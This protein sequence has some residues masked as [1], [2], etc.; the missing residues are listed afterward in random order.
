MKTLEFFILGLVF[1]ALVFTIIILS[2]YVPKI[3]ELKRMKE[4]QDERS[5]I[6]LSH[7]GG[8]CLY[9]P[10][11]W[12]DKYFNYHI[13]SW[14]AGKNWYAV[15]YDNDWGI[16][17]LGDAKEMYPGLLEHIKAIDALTSG[18]VGVDELRSAGFTVEIN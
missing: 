7:Q 14:D 8:G 18:S 6:E 13:R 1:G 11:N 2:L 4:R 3:D 5:E 12:L 15:E 9:T 17:I 10:P 16:K